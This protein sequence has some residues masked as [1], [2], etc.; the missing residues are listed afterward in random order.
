MTNK[1]FIQKDQNIDLTKRERFDLTFV[2]ATD[3]ELR[4]AIGEEDAPEGYI[5]G[6][7]STPDIDYARH[8]VMPG[9]FDESIEEKGLEG[10]RGIKL[11]IQHDRNRPAGLI[12]VLQSRE[13]RLWIESQMNLKIGYVRDFYEAAKMTGGLSFSVG[14]YLEEYE[15]K[16]D[17]ND[18]EYLQ[19]NKAEL[20]E[21]SVV[22][23]PC[24]VNA[25]MT[26]IKGKEDEVRF[27]T[28]AEF[29]KA[30]VA[31][32]FAN[33]RR[34]ADRLTRVVKQNIALFQPSASPRSASTKTLDEI[35][36]NLSKLR[37]LLGQ[38]DE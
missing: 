25:E 35:D 16:Q 28:L 22:T 24:N 31:E 34:E 38:R 13:K 30:L 33:S 1:R 17:A 12:K 5:A 19:I 3:G 21:V 37:E 20:E 23:F 8:V 10:P 15:F 18:I 29:E 2:P 11:L 6:W 14:F 36:Q 9:A 7:A 27:S 4:K 32:G 26:Y